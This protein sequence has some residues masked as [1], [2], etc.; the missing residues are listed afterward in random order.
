VTLPEEVIDSIVSA[1]EDGSYAVTIDIEKQTVLLPDG[2]VHKFSYDE[3]R[4]HCLINGLDDIDYI[5]SHKDSVSEYMTERE[6]VRFCRTT[7]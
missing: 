2:E 4:K 7:D 3:F 1:S 6:K 5:L